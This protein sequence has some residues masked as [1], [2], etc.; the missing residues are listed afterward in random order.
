MSRLR[1]FRLSVTIDQLKFNTINYE[2]ATPL[3]KNS[4]ASVTAIATHDW[5]RCTLLCP[6]SHTVDTLCT[7]GCRLSVL[8]SV[9][10][11][12]LN[13]ESKLKIKPVT[14]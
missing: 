7:D 4:N 10:C 8:L 3:D 14:R 13:R 6:R 2:Y 1:L 11:L 12:T 9:P 5:S